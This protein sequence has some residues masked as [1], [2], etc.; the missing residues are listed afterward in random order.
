M[1]FL[2]LVKARLIIIHLLK[3]SLLPIAYCQRPDAALSG[4]ATP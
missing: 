4:A 2:I 3:H 1:L